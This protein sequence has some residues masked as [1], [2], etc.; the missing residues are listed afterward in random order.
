V[1]LLVAA[2]VGIVALLGHG[3]K[4][5][6][7]YA[8]QAG[9]ILAPVLADNAVLAAAVGTLTPGGSSQ[10]V[11]SALT[12]AQGATQVAQHSFTI[13]ATPK[14]QTALAV[15]MKA[16]LTS[17]MAWL[18][19]ASA[20]LKNVAS[21]LLSQ[22][23]G[24]G[25]D[26]QTKIETLSSSVP[27]AGTTAFPSSTQIV[28]YASAAVAKTAAAAQATAAKSAAQARAAA[29]V[30]AAKTQAIAADTAFSS[31][32]LGLL[33]ESTAITP[34]HQFLLRAIANRDRGRD[35]ELHTRPSR[36]ADQLHRRQPHLARHRR[37]GPQLP[38]PRRSGGQHRPHRRIQC[39]PRRRHRSRQLSQPGNDGTEAFIFQ[40][41]LSA[42]TADA[43][44]ATADKQTFLDAYNQLRATIN[45]A[46]VDLEF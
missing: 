1:I 40:E 37:P 27:A 20:V 43:A 4:H 6:P 10:G 44:T 30:R 46:P 35:G 41:C 26:A 23:S 31:E 12:T 16:A 8:T 39:Q 13:L 33:N 11:R 3:K 36:T 25:V 22:L 21:P 5:G 28:A 18:Q 7:T 34:S 17:E 42:S 45:Q 24:L 14:S 15:Q 2:A 9:L 29:A 38:Q 32:V 19:T